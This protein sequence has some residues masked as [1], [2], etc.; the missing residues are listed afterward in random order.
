MHPDSERQLSG[1]MLLGFPVAGWALAAHHT[2]TLVAPKL[3]S[4][5]TLVSHTHEKPLL[6]AGAACGL[7]L[8][9]ACT[10][11]LR[12]LGSGEFGGAKYQR[13]LRGTQ[14]VPVATL[15]RKTRDRK[16]RPQVDV[17]GVCMPKD[18]E[19]RHLLVSGSTGSGK[20]V[21][22][23]QL[24]FS[25]MMRGD[26][27]VILDPNGDLFSKFGRPGD[28]LLN[29]YDDR[30]EGWS[31]FNE[32]RNDYDYKR[33]SLSLV[34]RGETKEAEEWRGYARVLV[35]EVARKLHKRD[36]TAASIAALYDWT[37]IR[38]DKALQA[39]L[40]GTTAEGLFV[41]ADK[42][43]SSTRFI[44]AAC[45]SPHL[46]M[47]Q[48]T[49]SIR[50][51][52]DDP[53]AGNLYITWREDMAEGLKPLISAWADVVCTSVLSL[54]EDPDRKLWVMIDELASMEKLASL[55]A[56]AT[57][58]RKHG[59]RLV[60][61]LQSTAQLDDIYGLQEAQTLRSC[62]RS[63]VVLSGAKSDPKTCEDMSRALGEHEVERESYSTS[64]NHKGANRS[65]SFRNDRERVVMPSEI[66]ALPDLVG[67]LSFAGE[68]P[69]AKVRLT[70]SDYAVC[71]KPFVERH[72]D[73]QPLSPLA[74]Y[75]ALIHRS[76]PV[77]A[78]A[79]PPATEPT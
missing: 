17:A 7:A 16:R 15:K 34:P 67:Y 39:F 30:T 19:D 71:Q 25:A 2:E 70:Y 75:Q 12:S 46:M 78:P 77:V 37:N 74:E 14:L 8:A 36:E 11:G 69:I 52:L 31:I 42:A 24:A 20:S 1:A 27:M 64:H 33:Y 51:W 41:G 9:F 68:Y 65:R 44:L 53:H 55:E 49:F 66:A 73:N 10:Y 57:K 62:F 60:A 45:L 63:M 76:D 6:M 40:K 4:A 47:P 32:F 43:L 79:A 58:G 23:R 38:S 26:R 48:G 5:M 21:L 59:I 29:P 13:W 50:N 54:D 22:F 3:I 72:L 56:A 35:E 61:G 18:I 28:K